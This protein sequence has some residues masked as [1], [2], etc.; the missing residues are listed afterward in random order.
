MHPFRFDFPKT[1]EIEDMYI[2]I[3]IYINTEIIWTPTGMDVFTQGN[4]NARSFIY[5][6][7]KCKCMRPC[8]FELM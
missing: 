5:C 4:F 1:D 3:Q 6:A 2:Y 8:D 7:R